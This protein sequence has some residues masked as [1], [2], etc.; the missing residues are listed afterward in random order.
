MAFTNPITFLQQVRTE[1]SKVTW[2]S[3]NETLISTVMVMVFCIMAS[4]FFLLCDQVIAFI[5][6]TALSFG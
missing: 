2:P 3:R 1:T 4:I 5:V 6:T